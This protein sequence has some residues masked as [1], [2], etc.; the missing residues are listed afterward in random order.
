M[1][2]RLAARNVCIAAPSVG[3][4][5]AGHGLHVGKRRQCGRKVQIVDDRKIFVEV[6]EQQHRQIQTRALHAEF[7]FFER[8]LLGVLL[9]LRFHD[10]AVR[11]FA[12]A[13]QVLADSESVLRLI[14]SLLGRSVLA[15]RRR[16]GHSRLS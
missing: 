3:I 5:T 4:L 13:F 1:T 11:H 14:Q 10:I 12:A 16:S 6:A 9:E 2:S 8:L 15:L 7:G